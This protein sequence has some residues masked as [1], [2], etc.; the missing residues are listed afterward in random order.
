VPEELAKAVAQEIQRLLDERGWSGREL[1]RRAGLHY[2]SVTRK[3]SPAE[4]ST[5]GVEDLRKVCAALDISVSELM[6]WA[7]RRI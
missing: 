2:A 3:L 7:E 5:F 4:R 6:A 1:S